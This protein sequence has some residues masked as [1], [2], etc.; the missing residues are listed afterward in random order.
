MSIEKPGLYAKV[1]AYMTLSGD[2]RRLFELHPW[3]GESAK[4]VVINFPVRRNLSFVNNQDWGAFPNVIFTR[5]SITD[6]QQRT[7]RLMLS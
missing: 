3:L 4:K 1:L 7:G 6:L 5:T 2:L